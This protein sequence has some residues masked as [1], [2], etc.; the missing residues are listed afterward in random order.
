[1]NAPVEPITEQPDFAALL[2]ELKALNLAPGSDADERALAAWARLKEVPLSQVDESY[3]LCLSHIVLRLYNGGRLVEV[4][5]VVDH[6]VY[7]ARHFGD[8]QRLRSALLA[9]GGL[10]VLTGHYPRAFTLLA[11]ALPIA[12]RQGAIEEG[13]VWNNIGTAY[14]SLGQFQPALECFEKAVSLWPSAMPSANGVTC[15]LRLGKLA[16][17]RQHA[18]AALTAISSGPTDGEEVAVAVQAN[19]VMTRVLIATGDLDGA[20]RQLEQT[21]ALADRYA[22]RHHRAD[23]AAVTGLWQVRR[24]EVDAGLASLEHAIAVDDSPNARA[25]ARLDCV[26][27]YEMA[28]RPDAALAHLRELQA[29]RAS[30]QLAQ[31][32]QQVAL[33]DEVHR[34]DLDAE[35]IG[36]RRST[37]EAQVAA[38]E[39]ALVEAAATAALASGYK[40]R[41]PFRVA[42]LAELF[43]QSEGI[44]GAALDTLKL[45][46]L[47]QDVGMVAVPR[48][49]IDKRGVLSRAERALL[50]EHTRHS[51]QLVASAGLERPR[52]ASDLIRLHHEKWDGSGPCGLKEQEI[53]PAA[54]VLALCDAFDAMTHDRPFRSARTVSEALMAIEANTDGH[55]D[56]QLAQRFCAFV[57]SEYWRH[58]DFMTFLGAEADGSAFVR[59]REEI[60]RY[61]KLTTLD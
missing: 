6:A 12:S 20:K 33:I 31:L 57:R 34:L 39:A 56:P 26:D 28:G 10:Y 58:P 32:Q 43:G 54:R 3:L 16:L 25:D 37:L 24:G 53:P 19:L 30:Q 51:A 55:F 2:D 45:A 38:R 41:R 18:E 23:I 35:G 8:P 22:N 21:T 50:E 42:K 9:A 59:A 47:L 52:A 15:A 60:A 49:I 11:E 46:A 5:P 14:N 27:G 61:L 7:R 40:V 17:A 48:R 13:K 36:H 4:L 44:A 1:M 29:L